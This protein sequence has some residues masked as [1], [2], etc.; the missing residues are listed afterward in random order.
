MQVRAGAQ[1]FIGPART[2][3]RGRM[4]LGLFLL[5]TG[6][7]HTTTLA[8]F[9]VTLGAMS[10]ARILFGRFD[11]GSG[12]F[13]RLREVV[14]RDGPM[15]ATALVAAVATV[16]IWT[17]GIWG[18]SAPLSESAL[19]FP[20]SGDF[21]MARLDEWVTA[22]R[23]L[24]NGPLLVLG[25]VGLLAAGRRW[26]DEE[27]ALVALV[28]FTPLIGTFGFL[29]GLVYP[30][31]RF[32]N[33]T[34]AWVLLVGVGAYYALRFFI[35][36]ARP[37]GNAR[38]NLIGVLAIGL[39]L[40][41]N[42]TVG[43]DASNWNNPVRGWLT[44]VKR[45]NLDLLRANLATLGD[46]DRPV[47]FVMDVRPPEIETLAQVWGITQVNGN[48][49]R[50]GLPAGQIDRGFVYQG[51]LENYLAGDP[52][53]TGNAAY[54]D[55]AR[56][57][58]ADV[59]EGLAASDAPPLVVLASFFNENGPNAAI[60]T[61]EA[62]V[63]ESVADADVW[64]LHDEHIDA[65]G[66]TQPPIDALE[67]TSEE[68]GGLGHLAWLVLASAL[69]LVPGALAAR[70]LVPDARFADYIGIAPAASVTLLVLVGTAVLAVAR[71]P[72][73]AGLAWISLVLAAAAGL[74][75]WWRS[76]GDIQRRAALAQ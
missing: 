6:V 67:P 5:A 12:L 50:Y 55:L 17:V 27:L 31:Y 63:P 57:S 47:V 60:A 34:L 29:L 19:V 76:R 45:S 35:E 54:D 11:A 42:F 41:T 1:W 30:Y 64:L 18:A 37:P 74:F 62:P 20:Y 10:V 58:L 26:V 49:A 73:S 44:A 32:F 39:I 75:W 16:G 15:L 14:R 72:L 51:S 8:I 23:P 69:L 33:T 4:G 24:L 59:R 46:L 48:T 53:T 28:W 70:G 65:V 56:S 43:F 71:S 61:G 7:T 36:R 22:M 9:G 40:A 66:D 13:G 25:A 52:T 68:S 21:F 2:S 38:L 3:W